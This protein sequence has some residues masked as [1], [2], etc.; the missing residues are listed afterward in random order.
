MCTVFYL[1]ACLFTWCL[2]RPEE[3]IRF[4]RLGATDGYQCHVGARNPTR[5]LNFELSSSLNRDL[6]EK[7]R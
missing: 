2:W 3:G 5:V 4:H 6:R 7:F 1:R